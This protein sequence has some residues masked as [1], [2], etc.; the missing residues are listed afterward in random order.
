[1]VSL[2]DSEG[3]VRKRMPSYNI[4]NCFTPLLL[5]NARKIHGFGSFETDLLLLQ[6]PQFPWPVLYLA[7]LPPFFTMHGWPTQHQDTR[8]VFRSM[9]LFQLQSGFFPLR[10]LK[11]VESL[12]PTSSNLCLLSNFPI[13]VNSQ[14][15]KPATQAFFP[16]LLLCTHLTHC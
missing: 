8:A 6:V 4:W 7:M 10:S 14:H 16:L 11:Y 5:P 13:S 2:S 15:P 1:M 9:S 3:G 12:F